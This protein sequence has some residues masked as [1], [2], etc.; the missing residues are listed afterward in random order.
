MNKCL[1]SAQGF[2][3]CSGDVYEGFYEN[4]YQKSCSKCSTKNNRLNCS[5]KNAKGGDVSTSLDTSICV[6]NTIYNQNGMLLCTPKSKAATSSTVLPDCRD[7]QCSKNNTC[8]LKNMPYVTSKA[9]GQSR[10]NC[11]D[12]CTFFS[13]INGCPMMYAKNQN[14]TGGV[15][16]C[17]DKFPS[18]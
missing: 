8:L 18:Y 12:A 3:N 13:Y 4:S 15:C 9:P 16:E 2:M 1:Y 6:D 7:G 10:D 11:K 14:Q 5:C 17:G